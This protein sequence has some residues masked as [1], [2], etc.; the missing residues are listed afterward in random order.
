MVQTCL[1]FAF[2]L[3]TVRHHHLLLLLNVSIILMPQEMANFM[4]YYRIYNISNIIT[5]KFG[6]LT[7]AVLLFMS[8]MVFIIIF[9]KGSWEL[10]CLKVSSACIL[11]TI[12][13]IFYNWI[14]KIPN[15]PGVVNWDTILFSS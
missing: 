12:F 14:L 3:E 13:W 5:D 11:N 2:H 1:C 4:V 7:I 15:S 6:F 8:V 9:L 10:F